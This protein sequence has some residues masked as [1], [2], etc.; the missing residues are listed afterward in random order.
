MSKHPLA[1]SDLQLSMRPNLLNI[2]S[3]SLPL[4]AAVLGSRNAAYSLDQA[5]RAGLGGLLVV[6]NMK[7]EYW[8]TRAIL[9][10]IRMG[11]ERVVQQGYFGRSHGEILG[12]RS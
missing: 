3:F 11:S 5:T 12:R 1:D 6:L 7:A 4:F 2:D 8:I 9:S 10:A